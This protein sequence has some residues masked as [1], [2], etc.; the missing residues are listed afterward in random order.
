MKPFSPEEGEKRNTFVLALREKK[1]NN[2]SRKVFVLDLVDP[3]AIPFDRQEPV[4][5]CSD[6]HC[7][8]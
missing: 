7:S 2:F 6:D 3:S 5:H 4:T 1:C 8:L